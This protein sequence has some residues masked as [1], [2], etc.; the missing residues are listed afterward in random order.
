MQTGREKVHGEDTGSQ[1]LVRS[2]P[3]S[4]GRMQRCG[5]HHASF[6]GPASPSCGAAGSEG[7]LWDMQDSAEPRCHAVGTEEG[8]TPKRDRG[9]SGPRPPQLL[10]KALWAGSFPG[11]MSLVEGDRHMARRALVGTEDGQA[12]DP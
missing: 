7:S 9:T 5:S 2:H 10:L 1:S 6:P 8:L 12:T 11:T 3:G 4:S